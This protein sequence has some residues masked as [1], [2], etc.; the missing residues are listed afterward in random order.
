MAL[1]QPRTRTRSSRALL[2][3]AV[4]AV[5][6]AAAGFYAVSA[7]SAAAATRRASVFVAPGGSNASHCTRSRPCRSLNRAYHV[8]RPGQVVQVRGGVYGDQVLTGATGRT[9]SKNVVFRPAPGASVRLGDV[10]FGRYSG[11]LGSSH[12]TIRN[13]T[14]DGG[15]VFNRVSD[16]TLRGVRIIGGFW[17][18]GSRKISIV[19]GSVGPGRGFHPDIQWEYDSN[20]PRIP[21]DILISGVRFHDWRV[22]SPGDH[23]EC[24]QVSDVNGLVVRNSR[25]K[26]CD[27]FG[28]HMGGTVTPPIRNVLVQNNFFDRSGAGGYY[29]LSITDGVNVTVRN[30]SSTQAFRFGAASTTVS[31]WLV[32]GN[33]APYAS[34]ACDRRIGYRYN[35]WRGGRCGSTDRNVGA[36]GF[37]DPR[38]FDLHLRSTSPAVN[39]GDPRNYPQRDI[40]WQRRPR[41]SRSDA[42]ADEFR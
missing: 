37:R 30:N 42:G 40:D 20:P 8:A 28:L 9:S 38:N 24:L 1:A 27:I 19:G 16:V 12:V 13:M 15:V 22:S 41:G 35:V 29:S 14:F 32:A 34:W 33:L 39:R 2:V 21:Q 4:A 11:S 10:W 5:A 25:F 3:A 23:V 36:L 31:N 26:N 18:N 17:I 7:E 6:L